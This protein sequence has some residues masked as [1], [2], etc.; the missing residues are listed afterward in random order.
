M[1]KIKNNFKYVLAFVAG[2]FG[3]NNDIA[4]EEQPSSA[5]SEASGAASGSLS[6]GAIAA[7]VAAAAIAAAA[8]SGS[9]GGGAVPAPSPTLNLSQ[10]QRLLLPSSCSYSSTNYHS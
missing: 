7:A 5:G 8:D 4:Q 6:A 1:A 3:A 10:V 2:I 9:G